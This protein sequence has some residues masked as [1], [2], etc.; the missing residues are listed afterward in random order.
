MTKAFAALL[1]AALFL[2]GGCAS[3]IRVEEN[4]PGERRNYGV[5]D[6]SAGCLSSRTSNL[7]GNFLLTGLYQKDPAAALLHLQQL[8]YQEKRS[9]FLVAL[10]DAA[11]QTGYRFRSDQDRS[12]RYFLASAVYSLAYLKYLDNEKEL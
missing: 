2:A 9:E 3:G 5:A 6:Y 12:S 10:A 1:F 4:S 8:W 11:L 7:L